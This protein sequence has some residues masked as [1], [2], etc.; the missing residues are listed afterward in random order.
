M[1]ARQVISVAAPLMAAL[2]L[3]L[4]ACGGDDS[5]ALSKETTKQMDARAAADAAKVDRMIEKGELPPVA[6]RVLDLDGTLNVNF[7]DGPSGDNDVVHEGADGTSGKKLVWDLNGN[8]KIDAAER[9]IT[10]R[11]LYEATLRFR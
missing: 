9:T 2:V 3:G 1:A 4:S 11:E 10:E 5:P 7:I 6:R 8:G